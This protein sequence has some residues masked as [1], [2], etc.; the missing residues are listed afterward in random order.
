MANC[1]APAPTNITC[2]VFSIT[3]LATD[4]GCFILSIPA[5]AP[6]FACSSMMQ[7]SNVTIPSLSGYPPKPTQQLISFSMC[8]A[9]ASTASNALPFADNIFHASA[10]TGIPLSQVEIT[11][12]FVVSSKSLAKDFFAVSNGAVNAESCKNFL[13][14]MF[15]YFLAKRSKEKKRKGEKSFLS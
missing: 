10:F 9:P 3:F 12:G 8:M 1:C 5:T 11:I 14:F 2:G 7:L 13:R 15:F 6:Q 4:T